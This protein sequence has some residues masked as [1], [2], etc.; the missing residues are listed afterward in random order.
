MRVRAGC[1]QQ[2]S[3]EML[4]ITEVN[5]QIAVDARRR[6]LADGLSATN[7]RSETSSLPRR[8]SPA[9]ATRLISPCDDVSVRPTAFK[10]ELALCI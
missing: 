5:G 9:T 1:C 10:R 7:T 3:A 2:L 6:F 8:R 4:S